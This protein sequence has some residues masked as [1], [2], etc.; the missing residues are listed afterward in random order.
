MWPDVSSDGEPT[1]HGSRL[2]VSAEATPRLTAALW[3]TR[4]LLI[5][6]VV[7]VAG[8]DL[9][10]VEAVGSLLGIRSTQAA[11]GVRWLWRNRLSTRERR[12]LK[13]YGQG[14]EPDSNDPFP[15]IRLAA[16]LGNLNGPLLRPAKTFSLVAVNKKTLY[17]NCVRVLNR[18]GLSNRSTSVWADRLGRDGARPCWRVLYKPPLKKRTGDLQWRI[19]HRAIALNALLSRM[20]T[21]VSDQCPFCSGQETAFLA[22][23]YNK[24]ACNK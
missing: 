21:A 24:A 17:N 12:L 22:Y 16:H 14:T 15:E 1:V 2:D 10:G 18:R 5:Q 4:T 8:P 7:A 11:E 13:D 19:L 23:R 6:H 3:R 9:T 20:N